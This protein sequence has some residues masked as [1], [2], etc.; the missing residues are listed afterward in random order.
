M[1]TGPETYT[2]GLGEVIRAYRYYLGL[3]QLAMAAK[4]DM[5][6]RTYRRIESGERDCPP[7][8]LGTLVKVVEEFDEAVGEVVNYFLDFPDGDPGPAAVTASLTG[9]WRRAVMGRAALT[10]PTITPVLVR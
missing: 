2:D 6:E 9:E 5:S 10:C 1:R 3:S 8:L 4:I 7:G